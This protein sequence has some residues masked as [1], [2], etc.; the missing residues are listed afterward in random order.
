MHHVSPSRLRERGVDG[1]WRR[2]CCFLGFF[3]GFPRREDRR[4]NSFKSRCG[5]GNSANPLRIHRAPLANSS[6]A[7]N[8]FLSAHPFTVHNA[9]ANTRLRFS[10]L[11]SIF[12]PSLF[13]SSFFVLI[14]FFLPSFSSYFALSHRTLQPAFRL[15][16]RPF[17]AIRLRISRETLSRREKDNTTRSNTA[18]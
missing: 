16:R 3:H 10:S 7:S 18:L 15:L 9:R 13:L 1:R 4:A 11:L 14:L 6:L 5:S 12:P 8:V 17:L 2:R